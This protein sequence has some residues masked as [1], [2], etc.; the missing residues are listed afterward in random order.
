VL[1]VIPFAMWFFL[2][3]EELPLASEETHN[4]AKVIPRRRI[5]AW[6]RSPCSDR[7]LHR[8]HGVLGATGT[9]A[10][11]QPLLDGFALMVPKQLVGVLALAALIG[12]LASLQGIMYAT[13]A[14]FTRCRG[15]VTTQPA[16]AY[17]QKQTP[18]VALIV[19]GVIGFIALLV[20][21]SFGGTGG[22]AGAIVLNIAI[23]GRSS[24]YLMQMIAFVVL[25]GASRT[26][27]G[28]QEPDRRRGSRHRGPHF[29][30]DLRRVP[31]QR[32]VHSSDRRDR[33]RLCHRTDHLRGLG[34]QAPRA[35]A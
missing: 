2:G 9:Q 32:A 14:T 22:T 21:D 5:I 3:I 29:R 35:L 11:T 25:R 31:V 26:R 33:D 18:L 13:V 28:I 1:L 10:S 24:S 8:E 30:G 20:V 7:G 4:P 16:L 27:C 6:S 15:P 12:L 17:R 34:A 23:W 19:G